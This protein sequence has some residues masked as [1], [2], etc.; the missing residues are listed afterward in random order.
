MRP[1]DGAQGSV[2]PIERPFS[3]GAMARRAEIWG[4]HRLESCRQS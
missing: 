2:L 4:A 3:P 1:A